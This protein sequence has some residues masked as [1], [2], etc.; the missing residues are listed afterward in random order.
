M[1]Q[2][3][4]FVYPNKPR[5]VF[6]LHKEV[7]GLKQAPRTWY[8]KLS[9]GLLSLKFVNSI[10]DSSLFVHNDSSQLTVSLVYVDDIMLTRSSPSFLQFVISQLQLQF[11][12]KYLAPI[13]Y[14]LGL[15]VKRDTSLFLSQ[16][17]YEVDL[18]KNFHMESV[19]PCPTPIAAST[20]LSKDDGIL[21]DNPTDYR[22]LVGA[23]HYLT[24]TRPEIAFAVNLV[25]QHMQHPR[26]T[27]MAAT[28]RILRYI[29]GTLGF[30]LTFTKG[31]S[32]LLG[33]SDAKWDGNV[34]ERRSTGE[35]CIFLGPNIISWS[36]K[37]QSTGAR[38]STEA[39]YRT[40]A[41][42]DAE[43]IADIFT[44]GLSAFRFSSLR[45]ELQVDAAPFSLRGDNDAVIVKQ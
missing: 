14:F 43:L 39:E 23:L 17:R 42:S 30:G 24:L 15:E 2:P 16:T 45:S 29:K 7:Y 27:H 44:K 31:S 19:K 1:A 33:F 25:C 18:L 3:P 13:N 22:S 10:T 35:Y 20:K 4:G 5:H 9:S 41:H 11:P 38:S 40:L 36:S 37:K 21:L 26:T 8:A 6:L 32:F 12:I 34:D 28:K